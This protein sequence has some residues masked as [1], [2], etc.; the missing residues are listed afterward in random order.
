MIVFKILATN[1]Q[2]R[3]INLMPIDGV[4]TVDVYCD[5]LSFTDGTKNLGFK[6]KNGAYEPV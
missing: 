2:T 3:N 4:G 6:C 5:S 1:I